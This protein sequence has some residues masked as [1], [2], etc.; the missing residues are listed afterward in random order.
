[1]RVLLQNTQTKLFF[2]DTDEWTEDPWKATDF[3]DVEVA[4]QIYHS[5]NLDYAQIVLEPASV[6][7]PAAVLS[8]LRK[9]VQAPG[10]F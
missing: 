2:I 5:H 7:Q 3:E 6:P 9:Y 4:A 8:E 1:M 10:P